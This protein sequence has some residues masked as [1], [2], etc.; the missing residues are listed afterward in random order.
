MRDQLYPK[1][2]LLTL[3][4]AF[5]GRPTDGKLVPKVTG[6]PISILL[7]LSYLTCPYLP[8]LY[9]FFHHH[10]LLSRM[11]LGGMILSFSSQIISDHLRSR[12]GNAERDVVETDIKRQRTCFEFQF[13]STISGLL[14]LSWADDS[15]VLNSNHRKYVGYIQ[16]AALQGR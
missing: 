7:I 8:I 5:L 14:P 4:T 16:A 9:L 2:K 11:W 3:S 12:S 13:E 15:A 1:P 10:L 6:L